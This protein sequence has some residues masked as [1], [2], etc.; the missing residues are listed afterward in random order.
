MPRIVDPFTVERLSDGRFRFSLTSASGLP[1]SVVAYWKLRGFTAL[2]P[3]LAQHRHPKT[4]YEAKRGAWA[5][6]DLL[7]DQPGHASGV[8]T[9][10]GEWLAR[11]TTLDNNPRAARLIGRSRPY[12]PKT[13]RN[14]VTYSLFSLSVNVT[15]YFLVICPLMHYDLFYC[16]LSTTSTMLMY[17]YCITSNDLQIMNGMVLFL[18][19]GNTNEKNE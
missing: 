19:R 4:E 10:V 6:I 11:F 17:Y 16:I 5:L 18:R 2:P 13:L 1:R 14:Y 8:E 7:K 9:T 12:S 15:I 3:E